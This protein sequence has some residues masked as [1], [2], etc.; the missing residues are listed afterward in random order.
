[1]P[2]SDDDPGIPKGL[3]IAVFAAVVLLIVILVG[4]QLIPEAKRPTIR[5]VP[6]T[7]TTTIVISSP[8]ASP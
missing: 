6:V 8:A 2:A 5:R 3:A 7:I 4:A 1:M